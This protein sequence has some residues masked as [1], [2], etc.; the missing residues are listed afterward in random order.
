M[1]ILATIFGGKALKKSYNK[2]DD[3][4][5]AGQN[6]A[7]GYLD[8]Y[9]KAGDNALNFYNDAIGAGNSGAAVDRFQK[10]PEYALN[11]DAAMEAG[12]RG[13][14]S[15]FGSNGM[16]RSG[17]ALRAL[18]QDAM[19]T[20]NT[21]FN[22]YA[23]RLKGGASMG[24]DAAG[25]RAGIRTNSANALAGNILGKGQAKVSQYAGFDKLIGTGFKI[26]GSL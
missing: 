3:R 25:A 21:F 14:N 19:R 5:V 18:S 15:L 11:Y 10:S 16:G 17:N 9:A 22:N 23:D 6:D 7:L 2:A 26:A 1:G 12:Q 8:P 13:V 24:F 4:L 20:N